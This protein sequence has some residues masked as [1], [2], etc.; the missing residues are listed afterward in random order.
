M[1][2]LPVEQWFQLVVHLALQPQLSYLL[3]SL[4]LPAPPF[5]PPATTPLGLMT[6][7]VYLAQ[8]VEL[9][10]FEI[11]LALTPLVVVPE[12]LAEGEKAGGLLP[13]LEKAAQALMTLVVPGLVVP[14]LVLPSAQ[15]HSPGPGLYAGLT[16][17]DVQLAEAH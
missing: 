17:V 16:P 15:C 1:Q 8:Q 9:A 11:E 6:L 5:H 12:E 4:Q 3:Y 2:V 14:V 7:V 13:V 10:Q